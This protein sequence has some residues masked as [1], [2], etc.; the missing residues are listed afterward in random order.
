[1][2][3]CLLLDSNGKTYMG[4]PT[5]PLNLTLSGI[6]RSQSRPQTLTLASHKAAKLGYMLF[7][8]H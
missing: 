2:D 6:E 1:M 7:I 3:I 5:A 4:S 8:K